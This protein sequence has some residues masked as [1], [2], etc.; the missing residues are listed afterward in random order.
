MADRGFTLV[1]MVIVIAIGVILLWI[2][3]PM[4]QAYMDRAR[5]AQAVTEIGDMSAKI[6]AQI[7]SQGALPDSLDAAGFAGRVDPWG[8]SYQYLNLFTNK[9]NGQARKDKKLAPLNSDFDLYSVGADGQT[10]ASL[11]NSASRDDI[12]RARDGGFIGLASDFDP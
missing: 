3:V 12:V 9:G 8:R 1:E 2:G 7:R 5:V 4:G 10:A 11:V 6:R